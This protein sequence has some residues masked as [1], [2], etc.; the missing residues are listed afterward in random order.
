M[1]VLGYQH[2]CLERR[3]L[4]HIKQMRLQVPLVDEVGRENGL[5][6]HIAEDKKQCAAD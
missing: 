6:F 4:G 2:E 1:L 3:R 5:V